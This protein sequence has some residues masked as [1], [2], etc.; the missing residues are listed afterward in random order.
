MT[1]TERLQFENKIIQVKGH[2][3]IERLLSVDPCKLGSS[4]VWISDV[5]SYYFFVE[6]ITK[7]KNKRVLRFPNRKL[8]AYGGCLGL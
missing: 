4:I 2:F 3:I 6:V 1:D 5:G 7:K 8:R